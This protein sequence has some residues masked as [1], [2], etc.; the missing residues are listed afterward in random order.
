MEDGKDD[1]LSF[2]NGVH[3][4]PVTYSQLPVSAK[5]TAQRFTIFRRFSGQTTF[6]GAFNSCSNGWI[7]GGD[8]ISDG[9]VEDY[10]VAHQ[11]KT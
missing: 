8:I 10:G 3:H 7:K 4:A 1:Y 11:P 9:R 6:N 5:R 2:A